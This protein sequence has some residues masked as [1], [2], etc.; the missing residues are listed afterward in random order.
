MKKGDPRVRY[1][2]MILKESLLEL[3]KQRPVAK[4]G[5]KEICAAADV[6][7]STFYTYYKDVY[8]LFEQIAEETLNFVE[9]IMTNYEVASMR[10]QRALLATTE[11]ILQYIADNSN[12]LQ[13]LLGENGDIGFQTRFFS[14]FVDL[15]GRVIKKNAENPV[16]EKTHECYSV[17][18]VYGG[19][20]LIRHW[21][22]N[23][24]HIPIPEMARMMLS[25][26]QE[27]RR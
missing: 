22:K 3:M 12:S 4:I 7:R 23:N 5:I 9:G 21:L 20:G 2:K 11:T 18:V 17:F 16:D 13:V 10:S 1:T 19:I 15:F 8:D 24:M 14:K 27:A 25:L 26:T 6:S